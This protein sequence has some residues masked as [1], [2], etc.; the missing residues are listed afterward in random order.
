MMFYTAYELWEKWNTQFTHKDKK[1]MRNKENNNKIFSLYFTEN[2]GYIYSNEKYGK[3]KKTYIFKPSKLWV[4][5][6]NPARITLG[7]NYLSGFSRPAWQKTPACPSA[8]SLLRPPIC[9]KCCGFALVA[10]SKSSINTRF[11]CF[12]IT[13]FHTLGPQWL[14]MSNTI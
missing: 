8:A 2:K 9:G 5:G 12:S 13:C 14:N 6:S 11:A 10:I 3:V 1:L 7:I 4:V